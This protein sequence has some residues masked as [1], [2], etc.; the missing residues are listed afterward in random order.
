[1]LGY[2]A[3][4]DLPA[5]PKLNT[6]NPEMREHLMGAAEHWLKFGIDGWRLDVAEEI[7]AGYWREFRARCRA[8]NPDA[9]IVAEI[10]RE[11]PQ[12]VTGDTF[13]ALMNYPLTEALLSFTAAG[14]IDTE[15]LQTQHE[16]R[17]SVSPIDGPAFAVRLDHLMKMY[18]PEAIRSQLNLLGSHDTAR[19]LSLASR[20]TASL[21]LALL[22][23]LTLPG[24]PCIY[25]GDEIGMQGKHDPDNRRAFPWDHAKWDQELLEYCRAVIALRHERPA[26]RHGEFRVLAADAQAVAYG[27]LAGAAG[28]L[29]LIN[30][31]NSPARLTVP[32]DGFGGAHLQPI[33]LASEPYPVLGFQG[34]GRLEVEVAA[35][36]GAVLLAAV[37]EDQ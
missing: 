18:R 20:D 28:A 7:D 17:E 19:Y 22:A 8:V 33:K 14:H 11:K 9:Y 3:W 36:S 29:V 27:R 21:R 31:G 16:Y 2:R 10:W 30:A 34:A 26:M 6:N 12:W 5:L 23:T 13:D 15:L 35:R 37:G 25:Y 1:V 4:W 24:A 32:T